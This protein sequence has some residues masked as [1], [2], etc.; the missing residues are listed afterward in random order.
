MCEYTITCTNQRYNKIN[1]KI[2]NCNRHMHSYILDIIDKRNGVHCV[3]K[4]TTDFDDSMTNS[5][6]LHTEYRVIL[7]C[8]NEIK[9]NNICLNYYILCD[10]CLFLLSIT[11]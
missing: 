10:M 8:T 11:L 1:S 7:W 6:T 9:I 2:I 3:D 4:P 5:T